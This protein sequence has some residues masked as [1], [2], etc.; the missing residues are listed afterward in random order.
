MVTGAKNVDPLSARVSVPARLS[1]GTY[2][3]FIRV[4]LQLVDRYSLHSAAD[5]K[6]T[7]L[8]GYVLDDRLPRVSGA[9]IMTARVQRDVARIERQRERERERE[10][11]RWRERPFNIQ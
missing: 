6:A 4:Q 8:H 10:R 9:V 1:R 2:P 5:S 11:E 3:T 7:E